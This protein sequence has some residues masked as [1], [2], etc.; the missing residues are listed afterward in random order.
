MNSDFYESFTNEEKKAYS[1]IISILLSIDDED[2]MHALLD[3][4]LTDK[5]VLDIIDRFL[6]LDDLYRGKSQR[7]IASN[8]KM[9]LCKIT[10]GSKMLKKKN[11]Y[12]RRFLSNKYDDHVHV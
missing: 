12:M 5:E 11:G 6:V 4:L 3:D 2:D 9:S 10:R 7:D 8:R 1:D